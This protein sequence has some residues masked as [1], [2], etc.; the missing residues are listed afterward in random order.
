MI[1]SAAAIDIVIGSPTIGTPALGVAVGR[2]FVAFVGHKKRPSRTA[3]MIWMPYFPDRLDH[4][5][6]KLP[7]GIV[8]LADYR[9]SKGPPR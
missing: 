4:L 8:Q 5:P 6:P 3:R 7:E 1:Y 2:R 9:T